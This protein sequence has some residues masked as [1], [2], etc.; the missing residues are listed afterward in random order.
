MSSLANRQLLESVADRLLRWSTNTDR[1]LS[2]FRDMVGICREAVSTRDEVPALVSALA[3]FANG[4]SSDE[5]LELISRA[6]KEITAD[7]KDVRIS[8]ETD[9]C[10]STP[11]RIATQLTALRNRL[12]ALPRILVAGPGHRL[13]L[14][15]RICLDAETP[16][17]QRA[18]AIAVLHGV[19]ATMASEPPL[20]ML[21]ELLSADAEMLIALG[22][23]CPDAERLHWTERV[24]DLGDDLPFLRGI[25]LQD[26]D[27][28]LAIMWLDRVNS[29]VSYRQTL[30][31]EQAILILLQPS[32]AVL[33]LHAIVVL[34]SYLALE[35]LTSARSAIASLRKGQVYCIDDTFYCRYAGE[36]A[37]LP[38]ALTLVFRDGTVMSHPSV[39]RRMVSVRERRLSSQGGFSSRPPRD[40]VE[41]LQRLFAWPEPIGQG[42]MGASVLLVTS[43]QRAERLFSGISSNGVELTDFVDFLGANPT[44][45]D[46]R[47]R[48]I[49]IVP[50]L[51]S[52]RKFLENGGA[53]VAIL[54][55]GYERL[56]RG[57]DDL[58][59]LRNTGAPPPIIVWG[60]AGYFP[61]Q[62]PE[63]L[64][65]SR[66]YALS[67]SEIVQFLEMDRLALAN[68]MHERSLRIAAKLPPL[69][70]HVVHPSP[71]EERVSQ[72]IRAFIEVVN[73]SSLLPDYWRYHLRSGA[74]EL[75]AIVESSPAYWADICD[76][77]DTWSHTVE[78]QWG[79]LNVRGEDALRKVF[80]A[81]R[82]IVAECHAVGD[83][84]TTKADALL[85]FLQGAD[86]RNWSIVCDHRGQVSIVEQ[87]VRRLGLQ[88][89]GAKLEDLDVCQ[90]CIVVG[91]VGSSFARRLW[92]HTPSR[93]V[94]FVDDLQSSR[95][96]RAVPSFD[97]RDGASLLDGIERDRAPST[98]NRVPPVVTP[99]PVSE[100]EIA[101]AEESSEARAPCA[102][103]WPSGETFGKVVGRQSHIL[104]EIGENVASRRPFALKPGDR[105][106]LGSGSG[107]WAPADEFTQAVVEAIEE[108]HPELVRDAKAWRQ[109]LSQLFQHRGRSLWQLRQELERIGVRR[110]SLTIEGWLKLERAAPI[111][112]Q[113]IKA[114][115]TG[116]WP[117]IGPYA[118]ISLEQVISATSQLRSLRATA[119]RALIRNWKGKSVDLDVDHKWL[120]DLIGE[121]RRHVQVHEVEHISFGEVPSTMLGWWV[122]DELARRHETAG[123]REVPE[124]QPTESDDDE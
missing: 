89:K 37:E 73:S 118:G 108:S 82:A 75:R 93:V 48:P 101:N 4:S 31:R 30:D 53:A 115:L 1:D 19:I 59:F 88:A 64:G 116:M 56:H 110:E 80:S 6:R 107:N 71:S 23:I 63:W 65:A 95:W 97:E 104:V 20:P 85:A 106:I 99:V 38:G 124:A 86:V 24:G 92:S 35:A 61:P 62:F 76:F 117:A 94:A 57:R 2:I 3:A 78:E 66:R 26:G 87:L 105:V 34:I 103:I 47:G 27:L 74:R 11:E 120:G 111:G 50:S 43:R 39:V 98:V 41:P 18:K 29:Y 112:P 46:F 67:A 91:W 81:H 13:E 109:A 45:Q 16:F 21:L 77:V 32:V 60:P 42:S 7:V 55:D 114:D 49:L 68:D 113:H 119:G 15:E 22:Q 121:L 83:E 84:R 52:A 8:A 28:P 12:K 96:Q 14:L 40:V 54:V 5:L 100:A 10:V 123:M 17:T 9:S 90:P 70:I 102:F 36:S 25:R 58:P 33:P 122:P 51:A 44:A 69:E 79:N 72:T